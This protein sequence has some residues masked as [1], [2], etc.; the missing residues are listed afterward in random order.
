M[1]I[2]AYNACAV[3]HAGFPLVGGLLMTAGTK[4]GIGFYRHRLLRV[5]GLKRAMAGF[6]ANSGFGVFS[7]RSIVTGGVAFKA[8]DLRSISSPVTLKNGGRES[9]RM[10][11]A[12]PDIENI[13]MAFLARL[14]ARVTRSLGRF[15]MA[16]CWAGSHLG[17]SAQAGGRSY[18]QTQRK[19]QY[20]CQ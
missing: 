15:S 17:R 16:G 7:R 13:L 19:E 4:L 12:R 1:A 10:P 6:T 11:R 5:I 2:L 20:E 3:V 8:G 18:G 9:L 14:R